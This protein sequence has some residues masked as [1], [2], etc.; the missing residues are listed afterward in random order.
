MPST[1]DL[2]LLSPPALLLM[3]PSPLL[4]TLDRHGW[5][6]GL[7]LSGSFVFGRFRRRCHRLQPF[8]L[9]VVISAAVPQLGSQFPANNF[10]FFDAYSGYL[11]GRSQ[12][13]RLLKE[14][15]AVPVMGTKI[16]IR[17]SFMIR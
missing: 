13:L 11:V 17:I 4:T 3:T 16:K 7:L 6:S 8:F 5:V 12:K 2:L 14:T 9:G 10:L 15:E 1:A